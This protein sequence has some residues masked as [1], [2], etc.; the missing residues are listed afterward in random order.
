MRFKHIFFDLDH[1]LWDFDRNSELALEKAL[2]DHNVTCDFDEFHNTYNPINANYWEL[3]AIG[4][5]EKELLKFKR[6]QDTFKALDYLIS[7]ADIEVISQYYMQ[8]LPHF[9]HLHEGAEDVLKILKPNYNL[10]I[11]TNGFNEVSYQKLELS[12]IIG[13]FDQ[14]ITSETTDSKK[15]DPIVFFEAM[16]MAGALPEE[17]LMVGDNYKADVLGAEAVGMKAIWFDYKRTGEQLHD[18]SITTLLD[19]HTLLDNYQL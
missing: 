6:F 17:S 16:R 10:H 19:V 15:P 5:I 3:Y 4:K 12:G 13:Y 7:D 11:I 1:T 14:I 2:I 18:Q 8:V 9:N